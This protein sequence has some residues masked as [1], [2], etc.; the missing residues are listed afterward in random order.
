MT[1]APPLLPFP[2]DFIAIR[3]LKQFLPIGM[4]CSG[5]FPKLSIKVVNSSFKEGYFVTSFLS[6]F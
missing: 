2:L 1:L 5:S 4:P 6:S 3:I